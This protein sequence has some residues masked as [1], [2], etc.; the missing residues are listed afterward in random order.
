MIKITVIIPI[1]NVEQYLGRCLDSVI[2]QT[3]KNLEIICVNDCS[4]DNSI[5]I[6]EEYAKKDNRIIIFN[7]AKNGGLSAARN[8]GLKVATGDYVYFIDSDD[9]I[10]LNYIE[11]MVNKINESNAEVI[12]NTNVIYVENDTYK[13][14]IWSR[15][16]QKNKKGQYL[17]IEDAINK[18]QVMTW[19]HMYKTSFLKKYDLKFPEGF[20]HEDEYFN[21][22]TCLNATN[23][24]EFYG[25]AYYYFKNK[26]GIMTTRKDVWLSHLKIFEIIAEYLK[27]NPRFQ[28]YNIRIFSPDCFININEQNFER[29][30]N[31]INRNKN[32]IQKTR[33]KYLYNERVAIDLIFN[34]KTRADLLDSKLRIALLRDRVVRKPKVS[35]ILYVYNKSN[36]LRNYLDFI[37]EQTLEDIEIICIN[38]S[39]T[40]NSL[41][42]L[43]EYQKHDD[44]IKIINNPTTKGEARS[45]DVGIKQTK[46]KYLYF[47]N[48]DSWVNNNYLKE[49]FNKI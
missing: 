28:Q 18:T 25:A 8:S 14:F 9:W 33:F 35:V 45:K 46:G 48:S 11:K 15:Y 6:I 23:I 16:Q 29:M 26:Q 30:K 24:F 21:V 22:I 3:Y 34:A 12:L 38:D 32:Y 19:A 5:Q 39:S 49:M 42:I 36:Y 41:E 44:R 20:I 7:R 31:F 10:D 2:N 1:Y 40:D 27:N 13:D 37:T 43:K 17:S 4:P 47:A